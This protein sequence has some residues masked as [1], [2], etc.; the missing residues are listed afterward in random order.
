VPPVQPTH[1]LPVATIAASTATATGLADGG[2]LLTGGSIAVVGGS[3]S[4]ATAELYQP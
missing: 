1:S 2:A 4:L 3:E